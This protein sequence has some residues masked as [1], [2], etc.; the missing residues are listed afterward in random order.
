MHRSLRPYP[1]PVRRVVRGSV[2]VRLAG[3]RVLPLASRKASYL[4]FQG[5]VDIP[6]ALLHG[7]LVP[8]VRDRT[9]CMR[10]EGL[11]PSGA[12]F[13]QILT[14]QGS[15]GAVDISVVV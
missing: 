6:H 9:F 4:I 11:S 7:N 13:V 8:R 14:T 5:I 3:Y 15:E 2:S 1:Q 12:M 10:R